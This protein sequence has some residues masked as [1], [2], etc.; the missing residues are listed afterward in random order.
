[1]LIKHYDYYSKMEYSHI[2]HLFCYKNINGMIELPFDRSNFFFLILGKHYLQLFC[3]MP[4]KYTQEEKNNKHI[5]LFN[6][7]TWKL[8]FK[9]Y[10]SFKSP[11]MAEQHVTC[12]SWKHKQNKEDLNF[13]MGYY[14]LSYL[15]ILNVP[16]LRFL[17]WFLLNIISD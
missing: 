17:T 8:C 1:M 9:H 3:K 15:G 7:Q 5:Y 16:T 11:V 6:G 4:L 13:M 12:C 10:V 2:T 14:L